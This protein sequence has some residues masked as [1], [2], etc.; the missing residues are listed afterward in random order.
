M[1]L[2]A[3]KGEDTSLVTFIKCPPM[4]YAQP[5]IKNDH[6]LVESSCDLYLKRNWQKGQGLM[7]PILFSA[8]FGIDP[9]EFDKAGLLDPYV[10]TDTPLFIDPLLLDKSANNL[11]ATKGIEQFRGHFE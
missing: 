11:L 8:Y 2:A 9:A 3:S 4:G 5:K 1:Y 10:N 7:R 6:V